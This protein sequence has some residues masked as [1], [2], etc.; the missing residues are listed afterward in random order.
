MMT[1]ALLFQTTAIPQASFAFLPSEPAQLQSPYRSPIGFEEVPL[2]IRA[3][4]LLVQA[5]MNADTGLFIVDT[6]A[7]SLI[8]N[9]TPQPAGEGKAYSISNSFAAEPVVVDRLQLPGYQGRQLDAYAVDL[10]HLEKAVGKP[11]LGMIGHSILRDFCI[12]IDFAE[13]RFF[14][15]RQTQWP[16]AAGHQ[17]LLSIEQDL[18]IVEGVIGGER[19]RFIVDL[20]TRDNILDTRLE[21]SAAF[22]P[23]G[24]ARLQGLDQAKELVTTGEIDQLQLGPLTLPAAPFLLANLQQLQTVTGLQIDGILGYSF[25]RNYRLVIDYPNSTLHLLP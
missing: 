14:L 5:V 10:S 12:F 3:G 16:A 13:S 6:G 19:V 17:L 2:Q 25:F 22:L 4:K 24:T 8:V 21:T 20:G 23:T 9:R 18:P 1:T 11:I 7:P 15:R